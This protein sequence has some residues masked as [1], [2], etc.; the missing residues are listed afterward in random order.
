MTMKSGAAMAA[1]SSLLSPSSTGAD[2]GGLAGDPKFSGSGDLIC[3]DHPINTDPTTQKYAPPFSGT[4]VPNEHYL[5]E[6]LSPVQA[7]TVCTTK[8]FFTIEGGDSNTK[9]QGPGGLLVSSNAFDSIST[10]QITLTDLF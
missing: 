10:T 7:D 1:A 5:D 8:D 4:Y 3:L 9:Y 2:L 6:N